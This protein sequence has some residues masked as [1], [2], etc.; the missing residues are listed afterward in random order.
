MDTLW[1][2]FRFA[3]R[4]LRKN[5][6][7][8]VLATGS[9]ALAIAGNTAVYSL[10]NSFLYRPIPYQNV[11]RL[12]FLGEHNS[13]LLAG[14]LA[15]TSTANYLDFAERQSVFQ[16]MSAFRSAVF[17]FGDDDADQLSIGEVTPGFFRTVG[18]EMLSGR[19]FL[20]EEGVRGRDRVAI[21]SHS[22]WTERF[23]GRDDLSGE[24]VEL[25]GEI[26]DVAGA[27]GESF[28]WVL[29]PNIDVWVPL[30]LEQGAEPRQ[31]RDVF[32][33]ARLTDGVTEETAQAQIDAVM[34]QLIDE[35]PDVNRGFSAELLNL[36]H[37]IPDSRNRL[38]FKLM[39]VALLFVLLIACANIANLLLS[40]SQARERELAI[41]NSIGA[42]RR[43]IIAQ[44]FTESAVMAAIA[45]V[46]GTAL[47]YAGMQVINSAFAAFL[48]KFWLPTLDLRVLSYTLAVTALGAVLFGL[49]P[50]LQFSRFDLQAALKDGTTGATA[51]GKRRLAAS[52]LVV[53][54]VASALAFLAGASMMINTFQ[55]LQRVDPGFETEDILQMHLGLPDSRFATPEQQV[56]GAEQIVERLASLPGVRAATISNFSP[57]TPFVPQNGFEIAGRQIPDEQ[58]PP[59]AGL[60]TIGHGYFDTLG[61]PLQQGRAFTEADDLD[62][63]RVAIINASMAEHHW[64]N[65]GPLGQRLKI[66]G[67]SYEVVGV[68]ATARHDV[69][70]RNDA[71]DVI[72]LPWAQ[73]PEAGFMI[74]LAAAVEPESLAETVRREV[75]AFDR[76]AALAQLQTLDAFVEQFWVGQQVFT[77]ILGGFG[78]LALVLAALGTYGVLAYSVAQRTHE[79]GIRMAIGADRRT[80]LNMIVRQGALVGAIGIALGMLLVPVQIKVISAIF[81]GFVPVGAILGA[82]GGSGAPRRHSRGERHPG[83]AGRQRRSDPRVAQRVILHPRRPS[84]QPPRSHDPFVS[85]KGR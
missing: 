14:Q 52:A 34:A 3:L 53:F 28:E 44:L 48:P 19:G 66:Q 81:Q 70:V 80:V 43:T 57:R 74:A 23:G 38:F 61:I 69:I 5:L 68:V 27:L 67:E 11:E 26:Y 29:A 13:D 33:L 2:N 39:Q 8:T 16:E 59:Q 17:S 24:T 4:T 55:T 25:N 60:L 83:P 50:V 45:G 82:R 56:N 75:T 54:E 63:A 78:T 9:L 35:Y 76:N 77:A 79:I 46:V 40:R 58:S 20:P 42:S 15:T 71:S 49:A 32:A 7:I 51:G 36:R 1:Q 37:D 84:P 12:V 21:L 72:Y 22:L 64:S 65:A 85:R 31:R 41:R 10:I 62:A 18:A 30:V 47:G 73:Q 6:S